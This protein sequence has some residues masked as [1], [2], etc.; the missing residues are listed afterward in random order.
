MA[1]NSIDFDRSSQKFA[2]V[3]LRRHALR[4]RFNSLETTPVPDFIPCTNLKFHEKKIHR[5]L[6]ISA[7]HCSVPRTDVVGSFVH[8]NYINFGSSIDRTNLQEDQKSEEK[9]KSHD[10][11]GFWYVKWRRRKCLRF[12]VKP[13]FMGHTPS[14]SPLSLVMYINCC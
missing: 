10:C 9:C 12:N 6:Y 5:Y 2:R 14:S 7:I 4:K 11:I 1:S 8:N 13:L 3:P